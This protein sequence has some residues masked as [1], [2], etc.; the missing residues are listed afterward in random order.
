MTTMS[1]ILSGYD[2]VCSPLA[3]A[4]LCLLFHHLISSMPFPC[5]NCRFLQGVIAS[6]MLTMKGDLGLTGEQ[7]ELA[8]GS[9]NFAAALGAGTHTYE[10]TYTICIHT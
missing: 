1:S 6:A 2:Q 7:E 9:L 4:L 10:Y 3:L 5:A 8:I